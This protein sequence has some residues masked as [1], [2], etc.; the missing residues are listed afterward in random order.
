MYA[1]GQ[2]CV[3]QHYSLLSIT[4]IKTMT[5]SILGRERFISQ[6]SLQSIK[7]SVQRKNTR[8]KPG[9]KI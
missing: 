7:K 4:M 8:Q 6:Y 2:H 1:P 9:G 3:K 5:K